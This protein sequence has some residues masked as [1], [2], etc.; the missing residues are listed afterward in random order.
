MR[1]LPLDRKISGRSLSEKNYNLEK[2]NKRNCVRI[3]GMEDEKNETS[4]QTAKKV[5]KLAKLGILTEDEKNET[6]EETAF[7]L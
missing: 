2:L 5:I 1:D 3:Y 7:F 6:S 4:E